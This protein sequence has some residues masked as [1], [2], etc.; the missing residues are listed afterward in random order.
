MDNID[1]T[2]RLIE[3][4]SEHLGYNNTGLR[5]YN[6]I[7]NPSVTDSYLSGLE[8]EYEVKLPK[9]YREFLINIGN[10]SNQPGVGMLTVEQSLSILFG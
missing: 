7:L 6:L 4:I 5:N 8:L 9:G 2:R 10:G 1:E 3:N